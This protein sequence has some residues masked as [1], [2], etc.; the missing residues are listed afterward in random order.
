MNI[1][2]ELGVK[3]VINASFALTRL[4][5]STLTKEVQQAMEEAN[6]TYVYLWDL[7]KKG[8]QLLADGC[9]AEAGWITSGAFNGLVLS[10]AACIAGKDP[11]KIRRLP[12]TT[13]MKNEIIIQRANRILIYD[14]AMQVPGGKFVFVGDERWGCTPKL[15]E[16]AINENTAAINH[17]IIENDKPRIVSIEETVKVAHKHDVPVI[18][19][20]SGMTYPLEGL[21]KF[22]E[23]GVDLACYGGKYVGGP[24]STGFIVGRKDLIDTVAIHSFIGHEAGPNEQGGYYRGIGRGYKLDR[25]EIVALLVS[26]KRW[27]KM[28]HKKERIEPAWKRARYINNQIMKLPGLKGAEINFTPEE[29]EEIGYH[30][31]GIA[32][33]FKEKT[34]D[35]VREMVLSLREDDPEIWLRSRGI[36]TS[37]V[38]NCLTLLPGQE[39]ILVERFTKLFS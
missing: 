2:E 10:A 19:D 12:D 15:M 23:M 29:G 32:L 13:G 30:T 4:G 39:K 37:F 18:L 17:V 20:C 3:S 33:N 38:I 28:D 21:T 5:G 36:G 27:L 24:N 16:A 26:F 14:R 34:E 35:E 25:Q 22:V 6:K 11:E 1:Y 7:M 9:G 31:I 8:G